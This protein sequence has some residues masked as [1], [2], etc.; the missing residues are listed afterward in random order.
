MKITRYN[1]SNARL[2]NG[3]RILLPRLSMMENGAFRMNRPLMELLKAKVGDGVEMLHDST[4]EQWY[5]C[6]S[7][8]GLTVN[9]GSNGSGQFHSRVIHAALIA[10]EE[11][12]PAK[13]GMPVSTSAT[14]VDGIKC[15]PVMTA[16]LRKTPTP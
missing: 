13:G 6:K 9:K 12:A 3:S 11:G 15:Y 16:S 2:P 8:S 4:E 10:S 14:T 5:I 1:E 7:K